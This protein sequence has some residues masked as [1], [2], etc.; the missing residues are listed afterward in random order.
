MQPIN[1]VLQGDCLEV[2]KKLEDNSVDSIVTDPPYGL[3]FM[4][5]KW[6]YDV[7]SVDVWKECLRVLKPG[8]HLLSFA[9]TRTHHRMAVNIEDAGFE[10]RDMIAWV[11]GSGFPK[12]HNIG[13]AIDKINGETG[14]LLKFV[15]WYRTTGMKQKETNE[16]IGKSDVGSHYLR[17]D[18]PAIP[19]VAIWKVLRPRIKCEIPTWVDEL[20]ERIEAERE[21]VGKHTAPAK[22]IY[23]SGKMAN[24]VNITAP[25]T[26]AAKQ[27]EGWGTAIKPA[28]EPITVARK[29]IE[30]TVAENVLKWGTGGIN[31]DGCRVEG[32][33][34]G[35]TRTNS[36]DKKQVYGDYSKIKTEQH[37]QGRFPAN[38]IHDGS[39]EVVGMFPNDNQRFFYCAKASK[40]DRNEGCEGLDAIPKKNHIRQSDGR[41]M[42]GG[43]ESL[44]TKNHH[45]T[46]KPTK[47]MK[48]L[49]RLVTPPNGIVLDPYAGSGSTGKAAILEGFNY[50]LIEREDEYLPI[51]E[52]RL[53]AAKNSLGLF[54]K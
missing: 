39:D 47:L 9:G 41:Q 13:K 10:I 17:L 16:I 24:D 7:P 22:S 2:L 44:P 40:R 6:D 26:E 43:Y 34:D 53:T 14:R 15:E 12:S 35:S 21:V 3:L 54:K 28:L 37:P 46:V 18:Q 27:W 51:I 30:G 8:G 49:I 38:L 32:K 1:E 20:V 25:A 50:L 48:Y 11:Y 52:A 42:A 5:K 29:P 33:W 19:T 36:P 4:G 31:V 45:P 23:G